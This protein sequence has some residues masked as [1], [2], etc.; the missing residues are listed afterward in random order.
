MSCDY[1]Y[2]ES[3]GTEYWDCFA[4]VTWRPDGFVV[5]RGSALSF[6]NEGRRIGRL[7]NVSRV[8]AMPGGDWLVA[9]RND[10]SIVLT[11]KRLRVEQ[12]ILPARSNARASVVTHGTFV[13]G[14]RTP[15]KDTCG[16]HVHQPCGRFGCASLVRS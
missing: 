16:F 2:E 14:L 15:H 5:T 13:W 11:D 6:D 12:E 1:E 9:V 3:R 4:N 10:G 7:D 8:L